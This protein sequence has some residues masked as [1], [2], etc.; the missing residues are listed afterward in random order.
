MNKTR[1]ET[2]A[3]AAS[4]IEEAAA[5][6]ESALEILNDCKDEEQE[7]LD[8]MPENLQQSDKAYTAE[9]AIDAMDSAIDELEDIDFTDI[10]SYIESACE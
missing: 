6:V 8:N 5:A 2:L 4:L 7:Y 10:V 9:E 1:R 3:R